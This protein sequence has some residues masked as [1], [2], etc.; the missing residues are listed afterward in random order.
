[1]EAELPIS[2]PPERVRYLLKNLAW[3]ET[4]RASARSFPELLDASFSTMPSQPA[5]EFLGAVL[6]R[7]EL[8]DRSDRLAS[9]LIENGAGPGALVG[10]YMERSIEMRVSV[11]GVLKAGAAYVPLDPTFPR[12][13]I[14]QILHETKVPVLLTLTRH[15]AELC[16]SDARIFCVDREADALKTLPL[17]PL[18]KIHSEM[19]AFVIF[20]SGSSGLPKGV[21]VAHGSVVNLL[22]SARELLEIGPQDRLFAITTLAFDISVL[23]LLL[24]LVSGGTVIIGSKDAAADSK[25]LMDQLAASRATVLQATPVTI[26]MQLD[27]G[28]H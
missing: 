28:V 24:P 27:G 1:M 23:E 13:R 25:L 8:A 18:P 26:R 6:S 9:W 5:A 10:I 16:V 7:S 22:N 14:E 4:R 19:R 11:L 12:Q 21:E 20:T 3:D 15:Q 17:Q 2:S